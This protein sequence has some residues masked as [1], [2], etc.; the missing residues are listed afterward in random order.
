MDDFFSLPELERGA[1]IDYVRALEAERDAALA[2]IKE[3]EAWR[4][5]FPMDA[6]R[7]LTDSE[8]LTLQKV[9]DAYDALAYWVKNHSV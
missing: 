8:T 6:L 4:A 9:S 1:T 7:V 5:S 2:R 3:L